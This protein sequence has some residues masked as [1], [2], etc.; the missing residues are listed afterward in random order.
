MMGV[1]VAGLPDAPCAYEECC[2]EPALSKRRRRDLEITEVAVVERD[3]DG[4][5]ALSRHDG[6]AVEHAQED[7][8]LAPIGSLVGPDPGVGLTDPVEVEYQTTAHARLS[9]KP[10]KIISE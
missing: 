9:Q 2:S 3:L 5:T 10:R 1:E 8:L 4:Q 6:D 7:A